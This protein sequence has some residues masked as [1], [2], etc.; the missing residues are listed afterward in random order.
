MQPIAFDSMQQTMEVLKKIYDAV[1]IVDHLKKK[2]LLVENNILKNTGHACYE[3]WEGGKI[4]NN[5]ISMRALLQKDIFFKLEYSNGRV[6]NIIAV[7]VEIDS[8]IVVLEL[9]KDITDSLVV[10]NIEGSEHSELLIQLNNINQ[11]QVR[12][13]LTGLLNR[14]YIE[15]RLP[16]DIMNS[17]AEKEPL[18]VVMADLDRFKL[19]N[20]TYGHVGGDFI[21]KE[22]GAILENTVA[23]H[24]A[25]AARYGGEEFLLAF[26]NCNSPEAVEIAEAIRKEV[27]NKDFLYNGQLIKIT[28]SFGV[29]TNKPDGDITAKELIDKADKNLYRAKQE[30]RNR[31]VAGEE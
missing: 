29:F 15:E 30:G 9:I 8:R 12:D 26:N 20:D 22:F 6:C 16:A 11:L 13:P 7:P 24:N 25:W 21:L 23:E 18:S 27:E 17:L 31:V 1:R 14:R 19:V 28:S 4:C 10:E 3:I 2:T 5:C